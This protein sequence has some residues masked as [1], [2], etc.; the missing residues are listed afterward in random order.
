ME[1]VEHKK[2]MFF[3]LKKLDLLFNEL[4]Y[5]LIQQQKLQLVN[6]QLLTQKNN[7]NFFSVSCNNQK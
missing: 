6:K 7:T 3:I 4:V 5:E 2:N 1:I